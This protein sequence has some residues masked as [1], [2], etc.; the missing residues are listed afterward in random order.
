RLAVAVNSPFDFLNH[1]DNTDKEKVPTKLIILGVFIMAALGLGFSFLEHTKP[2]MSFR[3]EVLRLARGEMDVFSPS[4]FRGTYRKIASDLNDGIEKVAAK[5][6][7]QRKAADLESVLGPIPAQ[8][9]MSAFSVPGPGGLLDPPSA[10]ARPFEPP[11]APA[12]PFV[13]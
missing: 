9:Q 10:P 8:P 12:R 13:P 2:L 1:A 4:R 6:G 11:S 5:G 7:A 3:N